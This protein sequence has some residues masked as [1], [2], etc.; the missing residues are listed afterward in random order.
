MKAA[1]PG[2]LELPLEATVIE[3]EVYQCGDKYAIGI[4]FLCEH[5]PEDNGWI[6]SPSQA[7]ALGAWLVAASES[8][9]GKRPEWL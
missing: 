6:M 7:M 3:G 1:R 4:D 2:I 8:I 5:C 9:G